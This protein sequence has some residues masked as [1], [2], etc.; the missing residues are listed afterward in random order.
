MSTDK[1]DLNN[2]ILIKLFYFRKIL[3]SNKINLFNLKF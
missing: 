1:I 3:N 2:A